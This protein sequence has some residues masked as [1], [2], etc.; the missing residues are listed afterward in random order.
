MSRIEQL[1]ADEQAVLSLLVGRGRTYA[2]IAGVLGIDQAAVRR[3]AQRA[4]G[5]LGGTTPP[6]LDRPEGERIG[7]YLLG[8]QSETDRIQTIV[9]LTGSPAIRAWARAIAAELE[10]LA[11]AALPA[12]PG[13]PDPTAPPARAPAEPDR[14][15]LL[16][17]PKS[18]AARTPQQPRRPIREP[19]RGA[20]V[21]LA[22][23]VLLFAAIA[24]FI[25]NSGGASAPARG[26]IPASAATST[27]TTSSSGILAELRM[28]ATKSG[29][30]A[31]GAIAIVKNGSTTE[32][33]F[34]ATKL[35][36]PRSGHY[37]LWLY[38]S[39]SHFEALGEIQSVNANGSVGPLAVTLPADAGSYHGVALTLEQSKART[40]PGALVLSGAS[41]SAL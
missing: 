33:T 9:L 1:P 31:A 36:V 15:R 7:D 26:P 5:A 20:R 40:N 34:S 32:I 23:A 38:D 30:N 17:V 37:V 27:S 16:L 22:A 14:A 28:T 4:L 35:P 8:Q 39:S 10:P 41:S 21:L 29:S 18:H 11:S 25:T 3:R 2:Q 6:E 13:D 12:V 24:V 19:D